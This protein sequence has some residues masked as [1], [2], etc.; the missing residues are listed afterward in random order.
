MLSGLVSQNLH[1]LRMVNICA[2]PAFD[3]D[4][5]GRVAIGR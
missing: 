1:E 4:Q 3:A 2:K 5:V